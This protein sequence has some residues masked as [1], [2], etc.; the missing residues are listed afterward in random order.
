MKHRWRPLEHV[1]FLRPR[2]LP[3]I[4]LRQELMKLATWIDWE[5][6]DWDWVLS[7]YDRAAGDSAA[8][9]GRFYFWLGC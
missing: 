3:L 7:I 9:A 6:F 8:A 5:V 2:L 4:D 1:D